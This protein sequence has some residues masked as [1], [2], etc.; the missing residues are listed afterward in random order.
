MSRTWFCF[1]ALVCVFGCSPDQ[2]R[3]PEKKSQEIVLPLSPE[4][5]GENTWDFGARPVGNEVLSHTFEVKNTS[6]RVV[7]ITG[8]HSSCGCTV[9]KVER[10]VLSPGEST[11][12][13][14]DF[15]TEG[16]RGRVSQFVYVNTDDPDEP[17]LKYTVT[18][19]L[20]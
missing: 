4:P 14:V 2:G 11:A 3:S 13:T 9:G 12:I 5:A 20:E 16:Y 1:L 7:K 6:D 19:I 18:A 10:D 15:K 8:T 17:V